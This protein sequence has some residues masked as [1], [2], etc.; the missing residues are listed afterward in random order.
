MLLPLK[1]STAAVGAA[2]AIPNKGLKNTLHI[3]LC[4]SLHFMVPRCGFV[5]CT[6]L[7]VVSQYICLYCFRFG[8]P[9]CNLYSCSTLLVDM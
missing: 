3:E 9:W 5:S 6:S 7:A 1:G 4:E 8:I 2:A